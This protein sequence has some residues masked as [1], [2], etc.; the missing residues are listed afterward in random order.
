MWVHLF[1][2]SPQMHLLSLSQPFSWDL[3][4]TSSYWS[5]TNPFS[6]ISSSWISQRLL[7]PKERSTIASELRACGVS[8]QVEQWFSKY[9]PGPAAAASRNLLKQQNLR[10][11]RRSTESEATSGPASHPGDSLCTPSLRTAGLE[12]IGVGGA[13][14]SAPGPVPRGKSIGLDYTTSGKWA[15]ANSS[16]REQQH[17][18]NCMTLWTSGQH[19]LLTTKEKK[20]LTCK[21][22]CQE[23]YK[24]EARVRN[25]M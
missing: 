10:L 24:K 16:E 9:V 8:I 23:K 15:Q 2:E 12:D 18:A 14:T 19:I 3:D 11:H 13:V 7:L 5:F 22:Q 17:A 21:S 1:H 4:P 6:Y 20:I 25:K